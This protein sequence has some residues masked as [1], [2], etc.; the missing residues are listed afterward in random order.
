MTN[1]EENVN[2]VSP[3]GASFKEKRR[4]VKCE[5]HVHGTLKTETCLPWVSLNWGV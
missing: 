5:N 2:H 1:D 3:D 4:V